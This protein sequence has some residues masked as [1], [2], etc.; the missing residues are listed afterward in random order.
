MESILKNAKDQRLAEESQEVNVRNSLLQVKAV[1][2]WLEANGETNGESAE[3]IMYNQQCFLLQA[4]N[5]V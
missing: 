1:Y 3:E 2:Q 5:K 4:V